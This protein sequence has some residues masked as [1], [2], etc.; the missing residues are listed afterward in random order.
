MSRS[1]CRNSPPGLVVVKRRTTS[2]RFTPTGYITSTPVGLTEEDSTR[3]RSYRT[4]DFIKRTVRRTRFRQIG[5]NW[6][7]T[8]RVPWTYLHFVFAKLH[9]SRSY[10]SPSTRYRSPLGPRPLSVVKRS[11][12]GSR[13]GNRCGASVSRPGKRNGMSRVNRNLGLSKRVIVTFSRV[14]ASFVPDDHRRNFVYARPRFFERRKTYPDPT[15][16]VSKS[17]R[18]LRRFCRTSSNF[19]HARFRRIRQILLTN[20]PRHLRRLRVGRARARALR[21]LSSAYTLFVTGGL[22][23]QAA[24]RFRAADIGGRWWPIVAR[25]DRVAARAQKSRGSPSPAGPPIVP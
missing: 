9:L 21:S 8:E 11:R 14:R 22:G 25:E 20:V 24:A 17:S 15:E 1:P 18:P 2:R 10:R 12:R 19:P 5:R 3:I 7:K 16:N 6:K 13:D 4:F 23:A